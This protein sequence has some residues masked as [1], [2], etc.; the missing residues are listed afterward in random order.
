MASIPKIKIT[1]DA[2][3]DQLKRGVKGAETEVTGFSDKIGKFGKVA[4]AAFAAASAA[5]V[6]YA[7]KL[8]VDGVKAAIEEE[9]A[10]EKLAATLRN[11]TNA[12]DNQIASIEKYITKTS[13][14]FGVTDDELRPSLDRL[15]RSTK[16]VEEAQK[17]QSIALDVAAGTGKN[18][19]AVS[20]A[21]AKAHDGNFG[22]LRKLGVS[23]DE[24]II[25]S[26]DFDAVT[27][28]LASTFQDQATIQAETFQGKMD[29]LNIAFN[30]AKETVGSYVLDAITPMVTT[31]VEQGIPALTAMGSEIAE[32][33]KPIIEDLI[34]V[35]KE[36]LIPIFN[37]WYKFIRE[38]LY[39]FLREIFKPIISELVKIFEDL[40]AKLVSNKGSF[41][42][43]FEA[44]KPIFE[45]V[46]DKL[47]P[48]LGTVLA[49]AISV[50]GEALGAAISLVGKFAGA[51]GSVIDKVTDLIRLIKNN[52][53]VQ[54][55]TGAIGGLFGGGRAAGG[56]VSAGTTY[57]VGERG[58]EL[59]TPNQNGMIVPNN[60]LTSNRGNTV[61]INVSGALDPVSVARQIANLLNQEATLN[62]TF[63][64]LGSSRLVAP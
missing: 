48:V 38:F 37:F 51:L 63:I 10:Q 27:Q 32:K 6:A 11:V 39:P 42:K 62:G 2:D 22:A 57:L 43:L 19:S 30:E 20:E 15:V 1:F 12:T 17:L 21:L 9:A 14:A 52:P 26:K 61:N 40:T 16:N 33:L 45:F 36:Y 47:A 44:L 29:R 58:A 4:A 49:G 41:E 3:F 31:L 25:K 23:I 13:L 28:I 46:R 59:F 64:N 54:N 5:A 56:S 60:A 7:G 50:V 18:L 35:F 34:F 55:I 24:N 8:L 53:I